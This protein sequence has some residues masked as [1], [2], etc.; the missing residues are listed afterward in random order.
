M[1]RI[2]GQCVQLHRC[3]W[4]RHVLRVRA[5]AAL[6]RRLGLPMGSGGTDPS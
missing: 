1:E 6:A 2:K 5:E 4:L 3:E